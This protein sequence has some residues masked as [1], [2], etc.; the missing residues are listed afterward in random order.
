VNT[1]AIIQEWELIRGIFRCKM[2]YLPQQTDI[3][4]NYSGS[5]GYRYSYDNGPYLRGYIVAT[6]CDHENT[7]HK[8]GILPT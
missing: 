4:G 3:L 6:A 2:C 7:R 5:S 8:I 1:Q